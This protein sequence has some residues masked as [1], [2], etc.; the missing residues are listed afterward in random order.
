MKK[1]IIF[2]AG[3][4]GQDI[5]SEIKDNVNVIAFWDNGDKNKGDIDGV[6]IEKPN[7]KR[8]FDKVILG[9]C[10][11]SMKKQLLEMGI[12]EEKIDEQYVA[13]RVTTRINFLKNFSKLV[14][15]M[16]IE[17]DVAEAGVF[18]GEFAK[19][20]NSFFKDRTLYLFD[21][22]DGFDER[23]VKHE[24]SNNFS[25]AQIGQYDMTSEE[26]VLGNMK[27]PDKCRV[28]KGFFPETA[29]GAGINTKFCF[30]NLDMDLYKPTL[31][32]LKFFKDKM[33]KGGIVLVHDYFS[34]YKG[35]HAAIHEFIEMYPEYRLIPIGDEISI[36]VVGF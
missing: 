16:G 30:V 34:H 19:Y 10:Y 12:P 6:A 31:E 33:A 13:R 4:M 24:H 3:G 21:T 32:G 5:Y 25:G 28:F 22:F 27:Y 18:Q 7:N 20:I 29:I 35:V 11:P 15:T 1:I 36:A 2:G 17:G 26:I 23:D 14:S 8:L 9:A